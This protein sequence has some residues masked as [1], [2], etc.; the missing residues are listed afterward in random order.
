MNGAYPFEL[1]RLETGHGYADHWAVGTLVR[2]HYPVPSL[3]DPAGELDHVRRAFDAEGLGDAYLRSGDTFFRAE[4]RIVRLDYQAAANEIQ[5]GAPAPDVD[6]KKV[7]ILV[8]ES[9]ARMTRLLS[10][11]GYVG[12]VEVE[13]KLYRSHTGSLVLHGEGVEGTRVMWATHRVLDPDIIL[14]ELTSD[15]IAGMT[16][17]FLRLVARNVDLTPEGSG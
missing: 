15:A 14:S 12:P 10:A 13:A 4:D 2:A 3:C 11:I 16:S 7:G 5:R 6:I 9:V 17:K 8:H 1:I